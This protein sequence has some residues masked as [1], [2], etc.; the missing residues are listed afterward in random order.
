MEEELEASILTKNL[1][2]DFDDGLQYFVTKKL[3]AEAIVSFDRTDLRRLNP[4]KRWS[5]FRSRPLD[6]T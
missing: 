6:N 1:G 5:E 4:E 2:L 3:G